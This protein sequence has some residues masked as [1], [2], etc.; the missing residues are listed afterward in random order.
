MPD[1]EKSVPQKRGTPEVA[2]PA[3]A[4]EVSSVPV[5]PSAPGGSDPMA[6]PPAEPH[7]VEG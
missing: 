2:S 6:I 7:N 1:Q 3:A 4:P 5:V